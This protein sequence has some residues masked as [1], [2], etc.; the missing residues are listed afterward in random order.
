MNE[1]SI[2]IKEVKEKL[3]LVIDKGVVSK[4]VKDRDEDPSF[5]KRMVDG[6]VCKVNGCK[7]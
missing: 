7:K 1:E 6:F 3:I 4:V 5:P 2:R